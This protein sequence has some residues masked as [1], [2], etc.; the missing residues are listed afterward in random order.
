M[1]LPWERNTMTENNVYSIRTSAL[2]HALNVSRKK[3]ALMAIENTLIASKLGILFALKTNSYVNFKHENAELNDAQ[4][5]ALQELLE[6]HFSAKMTDE[7]RTLVK[8]QE[9][10]QEKTDIRHNITPSSQPNGQGLLNKIRGF[11]KIRPQES[12]A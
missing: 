8:T 2:F 7:L 5:I 9:Q 6:Q 10:L 1:K 12:P 11:L 3:Q 4:L